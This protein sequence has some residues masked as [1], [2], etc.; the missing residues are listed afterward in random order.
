MGN[1]V[2]SFRGDAEF[3][4]RLSTEQCRTGGPTL[5]TSFADAQPKDAAPVVVWD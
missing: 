5:L 2:F 4:F 3:S 1:N